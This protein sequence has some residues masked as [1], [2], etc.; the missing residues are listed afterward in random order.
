MTHRTM[1]ERSTSELCPALI[2]IHVTYLC[3]HVC[4]FLFFNLPYLGTLGHSTHPNQ[5][6]FQ[7]K[8][9]TLYSFQPVLYDRYNK[10]HGMCYPACEMVHTK[11][12]LLLTERVANVVMAVGLRGPL[13]YI[14]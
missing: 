11:D 10:G 2:E 13:L 8:L 1:S 6:V 7:Y 14:L 3:V 5:L 12:P 9:L 4:G